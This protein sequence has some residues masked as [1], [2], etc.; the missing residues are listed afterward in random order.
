MNPRHVHKHA[1]QDGYCH[2]GAVRDEVISSNLRA[3]PTWQCPNCGAVDERK[4]YVLRPDEERA[5]F[6]WW[7]DRRKPTWSRTLVIV[8]QEGEHRDADLMLKAQLHPFNPYCYSNG[9][10]ILVRGKRRMGSSW[11]G[12]LL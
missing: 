9:H 10:A 6:S 5:A 11:Y 12:G 1:W 2:C 8:R 7:L 4:K 3:Y